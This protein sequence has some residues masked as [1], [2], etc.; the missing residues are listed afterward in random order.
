MPK[1]GGENDSGRGAVVEFL[2]IRIARDL[3]G[4]EAITAFTR[5]LRK[6]DW[7]AKKKATARVFFDGLTE[8]VRIMRE[9]ASKYS[10]PLSFDKPEPTP[11]VTE[12]K[13]REKF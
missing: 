4:P 11:V 9:I 12:P 13:P 3:T 2:E 5:F 7:T 6:Q 1:R 8:G 10:V